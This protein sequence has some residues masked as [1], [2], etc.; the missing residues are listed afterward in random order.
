MLSYGESKL[1][2]KTFSVLFYMKTPSINFGRTAPFFAGTNFG[3]TGARKG[4]FWRSFILGLY[5]LYDLLLEVS[6]VVFEADRLFWVDFILA[7]SPDKRR[8]LDDK[9]LFFI[10]VVLIPM[11]P[12]YI[13]PEALW[14]NFLELKGSSSIILGTII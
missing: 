11:K 10:V 1:P 6:F 13:V 4:D 8:P 2:N 5:K 7:F 3:T 9:I 12:S 14:C